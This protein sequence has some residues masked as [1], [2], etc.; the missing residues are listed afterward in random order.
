MNES[1]LGQILGDELRQQAL[2]GRGHLRWLDDRT[3]TYSKRPT[4]ARP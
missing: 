1:Y 2:G 4:S 3:V